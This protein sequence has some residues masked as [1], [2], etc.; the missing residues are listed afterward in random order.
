MPQIRRYG[1]TLSSHMTACSFVT[2]GSERH[3]P[4]HTS[5]LGIAQPLVE[6]V[7][8]DGTDGRWHGRATEWRAGAMG[9]HGW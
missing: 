5:E 8:H 6:V 1:I 3:R 7:E 2:L 4:P 9:E